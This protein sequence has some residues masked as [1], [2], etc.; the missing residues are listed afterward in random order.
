MGAVDIGPRL[1]RAVYSHSIV[2]DLVASSD[3]D[4]EGSLVVHA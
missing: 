1:E 4:V 2:V 3:H